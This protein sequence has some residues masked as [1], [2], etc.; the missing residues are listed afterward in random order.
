[1]L[2]G[3]LQQQHQEEMEKHEKEFNEI[4]KQKYD[5]EKVMGEKI[6]KLTIQAETQRLTLKE[7][8]GTKLKLDEENN[9]LEVAN[10]HETM[11]RL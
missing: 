4:S 2:I 5:N 3:K 6:V 1:M 11:L 9:I 7:V 8:L 10:E